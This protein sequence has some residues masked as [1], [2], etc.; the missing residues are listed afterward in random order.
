MQIRSSDFPHL[1][2]ALTRRGEL[3]VYNAEEVLWVDISGSS[4]Q[5]CKGGMSFFRNHECPEPYRVV[6]FSPRRFPDFSKFRF[7]RIRE[8]CL[9]CKVVPI[10]FMVTLDLD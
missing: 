9:M 1:L 7:S 3:G 5:L 2:D 6:H 4:L 8:F 10:R